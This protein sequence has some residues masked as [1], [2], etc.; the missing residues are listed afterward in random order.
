MVFL[1]ERFTCESFFCIT[2]DGTEKMQFF[3]VD[4]VEYQ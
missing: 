4:G 2:T 1:L 3:E